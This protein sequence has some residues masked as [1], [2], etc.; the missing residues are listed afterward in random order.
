[1]IYILIIVN[2]LAFA[3]VG[4]DKYRA[5]RRAWR[6][7]ERAFFW[8]ALIGGCPGL[9]TGI[10]FFR[11][12]TRQWYFMYGIPLIFILQAIL[13]YLISNI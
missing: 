7:P 8:F 1:M 3:F 6:I 9:Y 2:V 5:K 12:K 11:H 10:L 13:V 4:I